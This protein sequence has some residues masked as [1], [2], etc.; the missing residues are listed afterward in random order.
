M[1]DHNLEKLFKLNGALWVRLQADMK[2]DS[3]LNVN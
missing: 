1:Y 2:T 3:K